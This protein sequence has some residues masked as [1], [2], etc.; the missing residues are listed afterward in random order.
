LS[1]NRSVVRRKAARILG[2]FHAQLTGAE[3]NQVCAQLKAADWG[4]VLAALRA[5]R[6]LNASAA[7]PDVL[8]C[9]KHFNPNVVR[10]ACRTL[11]VIGDRSVIP[12]IEPLLTSPNSKIRKDAQDAIEKLKA[13][14]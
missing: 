13:K 12:S 6:D 4:E 5:L 9:L 11:A 3:L 8:P 14:S 7:V 10:D 1:D 2:I